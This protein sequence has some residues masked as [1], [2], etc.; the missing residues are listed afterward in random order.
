MARGERKPNAEYMK[1]YRERERE[2]KKQGVKDTEL[3]AKI[4]AATR[5]AV[6]AGR[7]PLGEVRTEPVEV[8]LTD[9][10]NWLNGQQNLGDDAQ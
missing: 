5:V 3:V 4:A 9:L 6:L 7:I 10:V 8:A 2:Q 1:S